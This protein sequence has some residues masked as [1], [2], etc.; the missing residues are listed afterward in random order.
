[1]KRIN[2]KLLDLLLLL[3]C[4]VLFVILLPEWILLFS[5][6]TLFVVCLVAMV[7]SNFFGH[8]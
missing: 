1:M 3:I 4:L 8:F 6:T 7:Q 5:M 2:G